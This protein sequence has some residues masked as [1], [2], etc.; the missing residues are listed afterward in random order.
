MLCSEQLDQT[1]FSPFEHFHESVVSYPRLSS[2]K[3][4]LS[5]LPNIYFSAPVIL[6]ALRST[7][8]N[9]AAS[10]T[11]RGS[12]EEADETDAK[13]IKVEQSDNITKTSKPAD[14][15]SQSQTPQ[16]TPHQQ[17]HNHTNGNKILLF[18][19]LKLFSYNRNHVKTKNAAAFEAATSFARFHMF[20]W[21]LVFII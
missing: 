1:V 19:H 2:E 13:R 5:L 21:F 12:S 8:G 10:T 16:A 15:G 18:Q 3:P 9:S 11:H 6:A 17:E 7:D 4:V 14:N 20:L